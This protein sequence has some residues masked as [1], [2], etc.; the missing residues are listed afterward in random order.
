MQKLRFVVLDEAHVYRGAFGSHVSCVLSRLI[1][2]CAASGNT[3]VQFICC[4]ATLPSPLDHFLKLVPC[5]AVLQ[6][7]KQQGQDSHASS[8][9]A[10]TVYTPRST[11]AVQCANGIVA[12]QPSSPKAVGATTAT[13]AT[14]VTATATAAAFAATNGVDDAGKSAAS[15]T[16]TANGTTGWLDKETI[17]TLVEDG[18][19]RGER[20]FALWK[21]KKN[22]QVLPSRNP[23]NRSGGGG[24]AGTGNVVNGGGAAPLQDGSP[25]FETAM[26]LAA[27]VKAKVRTL[28]FC[29]IRKLTELVLTYALRELEGTGLGN[30]IKAYRAGCVLLDECA[31]KVHAA[32][33]NLCQRVHDPPTHAGHRQKLTSTHRTTAGTRSQTGDAL[34]GSCSTARC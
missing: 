12:G 31:V 17:T 11:P 29:K 4:S 8:H 20:Y 6:P 18:S 32:T 16:T 19:A 2:A 25:I 21:P 24:V 15:D 28:V 23:G 26:L 5:L 34:S 30:K 1:R 13:T 33:C 7:Q 9:A 3:G 22:S 27:L 14:A 10:G